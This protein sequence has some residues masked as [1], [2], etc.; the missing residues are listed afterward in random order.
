MNDLVY[1]DAYIILDN[2]KEQV[3]YKRLSDDSMGQVI[4]KYFE[5][6]QDITSWANNQENPEKKLKKLIKLFYSGD[7]VSSEMASEFLKNIINK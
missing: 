2:I 7:K 6:F 5:S 3:I 1:V 4:P